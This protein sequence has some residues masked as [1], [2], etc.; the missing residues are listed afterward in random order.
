MKRWIFFLALLAAFP[1]LSTDMYLPS[2]PTLARIWNEPL[3]VINLTLVVFFITYSFFLLVYGP[4]SDRLGRR[5]VLKIGL[6]VYIAASL[7]CAASPNAPAL[8][9]F[10]MF[11]A[12]GAASAASLVLAISKDVFAFQDREKILAYLG[13][14]IALAPMLAPVIGG[15]T[16]AFF[17]WRCI[18]CIL[19]GFG[20]VAVWGVHRMEETLKPSLRTTKVSVV[21]NYLPLLRNGT[22]MALVLVVALAIVPLFAFIAASSDIYISRF[23]VS[24]QVYGYFFG[25]NALALMAG[26]LLCTRLSGRVSSARILSL[27]YIGVTVGGALLLLVDQNGPWKLALP[28][29]C[30]SFSAGLS[31]PP[32]NNLVLSQVHHGAGAAASFLMFTIMTGGALAMWFIS[33]GWEDKITVLGI[34]GLVCG[35]L[36]SVLWLALQR[37]QMIAGH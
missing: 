22:Y 28:M 10:R 13:V 30:I 11:Q 14:V 1:P 5:N 8:I 29:L 26:S 4:L 20:M 3:W 19:A 25:F 18:F 12:V 34:M 24:E 15:W 23:G 7:L 31:R 2:I 36:G 37:R 9:I 35:G 33:L 16:L 17:S 32:S 27:C 6:S 21:D